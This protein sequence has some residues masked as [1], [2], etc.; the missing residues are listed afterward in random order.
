MY[1]VNWI[2]YAII[3]VVDRNMLR[4]LI[5]IPYYVSRIWICICCWM[6]FLEYVVDVDSSIEHFR[7]I[8]PYVCWMVIRSLHIFN[9]MIP[10][11]SST[12]IRQLNDRGARSG[13]WRISQRIVPYFVPMFMSNQIEHI[14][15]IDCDWSPA[16]VYYKWVNYGP[17]VIA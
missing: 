7:R 4:S 12:T 2:A 16:T 14:M 1:I 5:H 10:I 3:F 8:W 13:I 17:C 6:T 11:A 9:W 15:H